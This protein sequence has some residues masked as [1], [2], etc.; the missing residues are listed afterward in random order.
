MITFEDLYKRLVKASVNG[1]EENELEKIRK[2]DYDPYHLDCLLNPQ[3]HSV[4]LKFGKCDCPDGK[5]NKNT[6]E[7][8]QCIY[9]NHHDRP[10]NLGLHRN[11]VL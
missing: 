9:R 6:S 3:N 10:G 1:E 7:I 11:H 5:E 2:E 4:V 8:C